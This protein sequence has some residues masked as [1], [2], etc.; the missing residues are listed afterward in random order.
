MNR[1]AFRMLTKPSTAFTRAG[2]MGRP[3]NMARR[4]GGQQPPLAGVADQMAKYGRHG[5]TMLAHINPQE[6]QHLKRRGGAG[7]RNP[8]TGAFEFY[9]PDESGVSSVPDRRGGSV[10]GPES[11]SRSG[12][13]GSPEIGGGRARYGT[14]VR[15]NRPGSHRPTN[16]GT[17]PYEGPT[18]RNFHSASEDRGSHILKS[19]MESLV[20]EPEPDTDDPIQ[21]VLNRIRNRKVN[22][23][24]YAGSP[25]TYGQ[26]GSPH[27]YNFFTYG[28]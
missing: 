11:R 28:Q 25:S 15:G 23:T 3:G 13:R 5:D 17:G 22:P 18:S 1:S 27:G 2:E 14:P 6:A 19:L 26:P 9:R 21:T 24:P 8:V 16:V 4:P 12:F 20:K 10:Q 7:T